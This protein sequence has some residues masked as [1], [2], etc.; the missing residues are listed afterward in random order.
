MLYLML[1]YRCDWPAGGQDSWN[2]LLYARWS[3]KHPELMLNQWA[4]PLFTIPAIPFSYFGLKGLYIFNIFC[5]LLSGWLIYGTARILGMRLPWMAAAFFLFQP[6]VFGNVISGLTEPVN[7]LALSFMCYLFAR[8]RINSAAILASLL[9]F[10]RSEG[11]VLLFA[12]FIYMVARRK[13]KKIPLLAIGSVLY[14]LATGLFLGKWTAILDENPYLKFEF[15][16]EFNPGHG[17]F[18]HYADHYQ[19]ITGLAISALLVAAFVLL[20]AHIVYLL[21]RRTPEEKSRFSFWL[22]APLF[23]SFFLVHSYIWWKGSMGSHGLTRVFLVVAPAAALLALYALDK[24]LSFDFRYLN[25][26]LPVVLV[27]YL[28]VLSYIGNTFPW[29]WQNKPAIP[30]YAAE[31]NISK[32]FRWID[33]HQL[34]QY[35]VAH[36]MP[37]I[38]TQQGWGPLGW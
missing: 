38:S 27:L 15:N 34:N 22:L 31:V 30:A 1:W 33:E 12:V 23:L 11:F 16:G 9:P 3:L 37:S 10:F 19:A 2:H 4:K 32:A 28:I 18:M 7:A 17:S 26:F 5:V 13:W 35:P 29:P 36:Q 25:K 14:V 6:V 20:A 8:N 24:L 21:R